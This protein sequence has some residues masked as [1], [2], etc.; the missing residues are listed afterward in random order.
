MN[1]P[2][3]LDP[4]FC[5][6]LTGA[7]GHFLWQGALIALV[8]WF[9]GLFLRRASAKAR[10]A[11]HTGALALMPLCLVA[12]FLWLD[13]RPAASTVETGRKSAIACGKR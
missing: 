12:T 4:D 8:A 10:Y 13:R 3:C 1:L 2:Y 9:A 6:R 11:L 5:L 7:L